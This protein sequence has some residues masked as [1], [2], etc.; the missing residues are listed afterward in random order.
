MANRVML[1]ESGRVA[2]IGPVE[3]VLHA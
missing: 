1:L 3:E 2:R